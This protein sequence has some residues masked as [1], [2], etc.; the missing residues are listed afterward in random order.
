MMII[1]IIITWLVQRWTLPFLRACSMLVDSALGDSSCQTN[2]QWCQIWF[3]GPEP[4]V[5]WSAV[6][7]PWHRGHT[8]PRSSA[9]VHGWIGASNVAK[10]LQT[11]G[12]DDVCVC[13]GWSV[14][15]RTSSLYIETRALQ[16]TR[17]IRSRH[18]WSNAS[19]FLASCR[20]GAMF[21]SHGEWREDE[22]SMKSS[23]IALWGARW[24]NARCYYLGIR[25]TISK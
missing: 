23:R 19:R 1:I 22:D 8:G 7:V 21:R 14:R 18:R 3:S 25:E 16:E 12:T 15:R 10:E 17:S 20:V 24:K 11:S 6:P 4:G 5:A 9:V 2:V 13:G